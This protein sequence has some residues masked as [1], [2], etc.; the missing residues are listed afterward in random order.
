[1][2]PLDVDLIRQ[3]VDDHSVLIT[4][5]EGSIGGFGDHVL[6]FITLDG[7]MDDGNLKFRPMVLPDVLFEAATQTEQYEQAGLNAQ[8]I[9]GTILRLTKRVSVPVL[10][11]A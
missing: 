5:E 3:L 9:K 11:E 10:E 6:H 1:M 7:L 2:K 8:H 4:I